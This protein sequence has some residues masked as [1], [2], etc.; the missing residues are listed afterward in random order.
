MPFTPEPISSAPMKR[1][2]LVPGRPAHGATTAVVTLP[3][4][5]P[6]NRTKPRVR[7]IADALAVP[8]SREQIFTYA[9]GL[10]WTGR[11]AACA[12]ATARSDAAEARRTLLTIF[13]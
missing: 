10:A 11:A 12:R 7:P 3:T 2:A 1:P 5:K 6:A 8:P 9:T 4:V 13:M